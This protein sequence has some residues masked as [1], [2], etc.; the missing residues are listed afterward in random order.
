MHAHD[1]AT[2]T[3]ERPGDA[4]L[5]KIEAHLFTRYGK[6]KYEVRLDY[7]GLDITDWDQWALARQAL[8]QATANGTSGVIISDLGDQWNLVVINGPA[9]FPM[10]VTGA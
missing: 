7:T 3:P 8:A 6:W 5:D 2:A 10:M 4:G 9:G 1:T